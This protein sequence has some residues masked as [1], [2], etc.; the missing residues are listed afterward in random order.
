MSLPRDYTSQACSLAR[1]LEIVGERWTLLIMRD[2][3]YGVRRFSDFQAHLQIPKAVLAER[4][5]AL[6][7]EGLLERVPGRAGH[8][9]YATTAKGR[10]LWPMIQGLMSWGDRHY[11]PLGARRLFLHARCETEVSA[12]GYCPSCDVRVGVEDLTL[13]PGPGLDPESERHDFVSDSIAVPHRMLE[14]IV[15]GSGPVGA[16]S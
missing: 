3:L 8:D 16:K 1:A 12:D 10:E 4:L 6:A 2:A 13:V 11:A 14:P 15:P 9:E 7:S 5:S